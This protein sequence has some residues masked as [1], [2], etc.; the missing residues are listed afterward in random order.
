MNRTAPQLLFGYQ[1]D[2]IH[3][4][5]QK[6]PYL[7]GDP[8]VQTW[9]YL[10]DPSMQEGDAKHYPQQMH[11]GKDDLS[12]TRTFAT[13]NGFEAARYNASA[14]DGKQLTQVWNNPWAVDEQVG[15]GTDGV[16]NQPFLK[17]ST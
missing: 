8:A 4:Y 11:T 12:K 1:D 13:I 6:D 3:N 2:V 7:G 17:A 16:M 15:L 14:F 10:S 9:L 5:Q